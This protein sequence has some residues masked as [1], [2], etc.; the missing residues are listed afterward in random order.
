[1]PLM[2]CVVLD[3]VMWRINIHDYR[4]MLRISFHQPNCMRMSLILYIYIYIF[5]NH[6]PNTHSHI[7][8]L[9]QLKTYGPYDILCPQTK[10][11]FTKP[12]LRFGLVNE[13]FFFPGIKR[14]I[15]P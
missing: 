2:Y 1:M 4:H 14:H 3:I 9:S 13:T 6:Y 8:I 12:Q 10:V 15:G 5:H 7:E 11:S